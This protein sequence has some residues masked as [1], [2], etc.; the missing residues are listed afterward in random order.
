MGQS[1]LAILAANVKR[2]R[3]AESW[4]QPDLA[5]RSGVPQTTISA[6]ENAKHKVSVAK[7]EM[8]AKAFRLPTW[9]LLMPEIDVALFRENGLAKIVDT[10]IALP[11]DRREEI[12][13]VS[14][15]ESHYH[16]NR[17]PKT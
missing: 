10:Y 6:I 2:L 7:V 16:M 8:L 3:D 13:R 17:E 1:S 5:R 4:S 14:E 9:A 11:P 15:R 12:S